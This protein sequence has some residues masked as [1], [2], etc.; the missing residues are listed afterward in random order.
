MVNFVVTGSDPRKPQRGWQE[1]SGALC[2]E[3]GGA[4]GGAGR[5]ASGVGGPRHW[6]GSSLC[7]GAPSPLPRV[8]LPG[9]HAPPPPDC[10]QEQSVPEAR[11]ESRKLP[12]AGL[13]VQLRERHVAGFAAGVP[14]DVR[15]VQPAVL[16]DPEPL[17]QLA[18]QLQRLQP[19]VVPESEPAPAQ[20]PLPLAPAPPEEVPALLALVL[21]EPVAVPQPPRVLGEALRGLQAALP[22]ALA[23]PLPQPLPLSGAVV[24]PQGRCA[25]AGAALLR[26][27]SH[28]VPGG[29]QELAGQIQD[30]V[31]EPNAVSL[32]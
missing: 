6:R 31:A 22:L 5:S 17:A 2:G 1:K 3:Q 23:G 29:A 19:V 30:E 32:E 18:V 25:G 7:P 15:P 11:S 14:L 9:P 20:V 26:L 27:R 4:G 28:G 13:D 24:P 12:A 8:S 10:S 16:G 21:A